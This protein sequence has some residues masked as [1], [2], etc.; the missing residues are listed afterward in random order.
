MTDVTEQKK[1]ERALVE[2]TRRTVVANKLIT[3]K[4]L[5]LEALNN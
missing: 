3:E 5:M 1:A 4:N 2:A